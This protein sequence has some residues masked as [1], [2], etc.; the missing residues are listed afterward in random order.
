MGGYEYGDEQPVHIVYVPEYWISIYAETFHEY[1]EYCKASK[2]EKPGDEGW[3]RGERPAI[4][5]SWDDVKKYMSWLREEYSLPTEA[6]WEK[7]ARGSLGR[8]Y[9][10]GNDEQN[11]DTC[12]FRGK[13]T[14]NVQKFEPQMFGIH[15]M[16]GNV[17]EWVEDDYHDYKEIPKDGITWIG[18]PRGSNRVIRG[19]SWFNSTRNCRSAIRSRLGPGLRSNYL[20]FRLSRSVTLAL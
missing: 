4:N 7:A 14:I 9:L 10:W 12:N 5:V 20:G 3:G 15:Q 19:G 16:A 1:D 13:K 8:K 11:K 17:W 18:S 6:Q 2:E